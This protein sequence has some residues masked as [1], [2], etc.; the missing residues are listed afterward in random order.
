MNLNIYLFQINFY[1]Q[2]LE[3]ININQLRKSLIKFI[4]N[5]LFL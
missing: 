3:I 4:I 1:K 2:E 5:E